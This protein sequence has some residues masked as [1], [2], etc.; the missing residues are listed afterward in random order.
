MGIRKRVKKLILPLI[1]RNPE[2]KPAGAPPNRAVARPVYDEPEPVSPRGDAEP[3]AWIDE[4]VKGHPL[5]LFMKGSPLSPQCGF[6][7][8]AA[9]ILKATGHPIHHVDVL[10][11]GDVRE[12]VK[13]YSEWPTIP[14][15]FI[16]GE[17][18]GGSDILTE[19]NG[20]GELQEALA[21]AF[22]PE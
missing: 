9:G 20:N 14:Q 17:F 11:D 4:Q 22:K 7:A 21:E 5:V 1:G 13:D 18:F 3:K 2:P 6:S 10:L 19:M 16:G 12:A 8:N 15:I